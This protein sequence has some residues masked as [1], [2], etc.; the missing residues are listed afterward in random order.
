MLTRNCA[1]SAP[2]LTRQGGTGEGRRRC[3]C[4]CGGRRFDI[5]PAVN[6]G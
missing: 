3:D 4:P 2:I 1:A 6:Q 5:R